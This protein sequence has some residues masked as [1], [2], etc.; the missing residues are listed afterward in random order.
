M[1]AP[2]NLE[3]LLLE[4]VNAAR[5][6]PL[7][8]ASR[9]LSSYIPLTS[10]D[11][12]IQNATSFFGVSGSALFGAL[13]ALPPAR[14]LAWN[15][16]LA[17]AARAH[18]QAMI[19]T[20]SQEHQ[21]AGESAL[22]TRVQAAGYNFNL[23]GENIFA[24][25]DSML[26]AHAG[27]MIDWGNG[28]GGMQSPP[29]HRLNIMHAS[30]RE[31]GLG[32]LQDSNPGTSVGPFVVTEDLGRAQNSPDVFLL[33]VAYHDNDGNSFYS[34]GEG[35]AGISVSAVGA[36]V[37]AT[38]SSGGYALGIAAGT[39]TIQMA[40]GDLPGPVVFSAALTSGTNAKFDAAGSSTLLTSVSVSLVSGVATVRGL[41]VAGLTLIAAGGNESLIGTLG[42]DTLL[43]GGGDDSLSG[44]GGND[45]ISG[46]P[47][48]DTAS[49]SGTAA[50]YSMVLNSNGIWT[51]SGPDGTDFLDQIE[52]LRFGNSA[53]V[54]LSSGLDGDNVITGDAGTN[55]LGGG[56]GSDTIF[57]LAGNDWIEADSNADPAATGNDV[58]VAGDGDDIVFGGPGDD[59]VAAGSGFDT[60]VGEAGNDALNGE[61]GNDA[62]DGGEG[63]DTLLG[64]D[65]QDILFGSP[66]GDLVYGG[67]GDDIMMGNRGDPNDL[68]DGVDLM[69]GEA[70]N[71]QLHG[72]AGNDGINAGDGNDV[73]DGS[74][75]NDV[76]VGGPGA[77]IM[78][79]S[80]ADAF[81][82]VTAGN[83][84]FVYY[85]MHEAGDSIH[86]FD[87]R[88]NNQDDIHLISMFDGL[89]ITGNSLAA[90]GA[91]GHLR[92]L[93]TGADVAVQV[94]VNG[95][96][97]SYATLVT[98]AG[99]ANVSSVTD[100]NF[101]FH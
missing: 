6:D 23:V 91:S 17:D 28:P 97:D 95:G 47:G 15:N 89:G 12:D 85:G 24:F 83:D 62:I 92:V 86:G 2:T 87:T 22:G 7:G 8:D 68:A 88:T 30:F 63:N 96:G 33:G 80:N 82:I 20:D 54:P 52:F 9:Y 13:G 35:R 66:G 19:D 72:G 59:V 41:G 18:S 60:V 73:I 74:N 58:V 31:A 75:G 1:A 78:L 93:D 90:L 3:Q 56:G 29:G 32:V 50:S 39:Y 49:F 27:F 70:G 67:N 40:G 71:D 79:G 21:V 100:A 16:A 14:P 45:A 42:G 25:G 65:D 55:T 99:V 77:D 101:L 76:I 61:G 53:P 98:L 69:F 11:P 48:S 44:G 84:I 36:G 4:Y 37:T 34:P 5:L 38:T 64:W 10:P 26:H 51:V 81:G 43:G 94:D 46:G 57:G